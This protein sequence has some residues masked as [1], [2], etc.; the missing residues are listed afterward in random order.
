MN[1]KTCHTLT[2]IF[3]LCL[4]VKA[5][6]DYS[7]YAWF[8]SD[9]LARPGLSS[10]V[11]R[12]VTTQPFGNK[13]MTGV[14]TTESFYDEAGRLTETAISNDQGLISRTTFDYD[15][16][17]GRLDYVVF[18]N[19]KS[20]QEAFAEYDSLGRLSQV[21]TCPEDKPCQLRHYAYD[22]DKTERTYVARRTINLE[23]SSRKTRTLFGLA[24]T[25]K[26][27]DELVRERF[28]SPENRLE[29][30]RY[31]IKDTFCYGLSFDYDPAGR[32]TK[33]WY[34][35]H[36]TNTLAMEFEYD[37]TGLPASEKTLARVEKCEIRKSPDLLREV[38]FEYDDQ[39]RLLRTESGNGRFST[40][41][42][43]KYQ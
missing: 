33:M 32:K 31:F 40:V 34:S 20:K 14:T 42:E 39:K 17:S 22:A 9:S 18:R 3:V 2:L 30:V 5:Q 25:E 8:E 41:R 4:S 28:F 13:V 1:N 11:I 6:G 29:E 27:T 26:Q 15:S 37:E 12:Q 36:L 19:S 10:I 23:R 43:Y 21:L 24:A 35:N 38:F 16:L 7:V